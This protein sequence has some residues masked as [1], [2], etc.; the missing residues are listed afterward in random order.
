MLV[1]LKHKLYSNPITEFKSYCFTLN[2]S[3]VSKFLKEIES[4]S[5]YVYETQRWWK[6]MGRSAVSASILFFGLEWVPLTVAGGIKVP[7]AYPQ[8]SIFLLL[9][10]VWPRTRWLCSTVVGILNFKAMTKEQIK[11]Y[12][13]VISAYIGNFFLEGAKARVTRKSVRWL[14]IFLISILSCSFCKIP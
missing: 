9:F 3:S 12:S 13:T 8:L 2:S 5:T 7:E 6:E 11:S 4:D 1:L 14:N 10:R